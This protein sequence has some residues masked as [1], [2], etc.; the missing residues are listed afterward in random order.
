MGDLLDGMKLGNAPTGGKGRGNPTPP[1]SEPEAVQENRAG[2]V[3]LLGISLEA[4]VGGALMRLE[5]DGATDPA[6]VKAWL[7]G[8]DPSAKVRDDFPK[9]GKFGGGK[10]TKLARVMVVTVRVTDT[11]KFIDLA[12]Q[13]GEDIPVSVSKRNSDTFLAD[14][15]ALGRLSDKSLAKLEKAFM[16]KGQAMVIVPETEAFGCR[17]WSTDDG[18]AFMDSLTTEMPAPKEGEGHE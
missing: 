16:E 10:D 9:M 17:Y 2:G 11:G 12:C 1:A 5:F 15:K 13:N 6:Q 4:V 18:K 8:V 3:L 7:L 14:L